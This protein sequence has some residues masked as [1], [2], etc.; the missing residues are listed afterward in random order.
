MARAARAGYNQDEGKCRQPEVHQTADRMV[1][2]SFWTTSTTRSTS[3]KLVLKTPIECWSYDPSGEEPPVPYGQGNKY[4]WTVLNEHVCGGK[5]QPLVPLAFDA[6][7][8]PNGHVIVPGL[9]SLF[10]SVQQWAQ[11]AK[12]TVSPDAAKILVVD[13]PGTKARSGAYGPGRPGPGCAVLTLKSVEPPP[14][15][16]LGLLQKLTL[17][18]GKHMKRRSC[19]SRAPSNNMKREEHILREILCAQIRL[20]KATHPNEQRLSREALYMLR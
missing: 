12:G 14:R 13:C 1:R 16:Y 6:I 4:T 19:T 8:V 11:W 5:E 7:L 18:K 3:G 2:S 15:N 17:M 9:A 20:D 10:S